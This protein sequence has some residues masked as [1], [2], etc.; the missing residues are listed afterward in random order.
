MSN[1]ITYL[2][3]AGHMVASAMV[4]QDHYAGFGD[5]REASMRGLRGRVEEAMMWIENPMSG[6]TMNDD[7]LERLNAIVTDLD[8]EL[9]QCLNTPSNSPPVS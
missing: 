3:H 9:D 8:E 7:E 5:T 2:A 6:L 4:G 1:F